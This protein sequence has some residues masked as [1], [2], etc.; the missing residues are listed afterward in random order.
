MRANLLLLILILG[1]GCRERVNPYD[2]GGEDFMTP[3]PIYYS[4]PI[5][6][7]FNNYGQLIGVRMQVDFV[8]PFPRSFEIMNVLYRGTEELARDS[9]PVG[10]GMDSYIVD[11][12]TDTIMDTGEYLVLYYWDEFSIGSCLF[13][14]FLKD[15]TYFIQNVS[16]YDIYYQEY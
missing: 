6:G 4:Q 15:D 10:S 1:V 2:P 16:E 7:W 5:L 9:I 12:I 8:E 11:L 3:P 13:Y 14:I